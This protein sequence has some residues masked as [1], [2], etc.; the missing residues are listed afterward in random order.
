TGTMLIGNNDVAGSGPAFHA[1]NPASGETL[2]PAYPGGDQVNVDAAVLLA[3]QAF[4]SYRATTPEQ[5]AA[6]PREIGK[7]IMALGDTLIE[8]TMQETGLPR[9]RLE[10]ERGRTVNQLG[11]FA[12]VVQA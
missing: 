5:R 7:Q 3:D 10:G 11:L 1:I 12:D 2:S 8:R 4:A 9:A 6:F